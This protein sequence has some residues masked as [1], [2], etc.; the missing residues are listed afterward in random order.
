MYNI[1]NYLFSYNYL[2]RFEFFLLGIDI[3]NDEVEKC[4]VIFNDKCY[5]CTV[6]SIGFF[7]VWSGCRVGFKEVLL[8]F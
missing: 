4:I 1:Y 3:V 5:G 8:K 2:I 6:V 7:C